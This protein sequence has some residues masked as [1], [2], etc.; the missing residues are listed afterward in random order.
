MQTQNYLVTLGAVTFS[1][2]CESEINH[3]IINLRLE[4]KDFGYSRK[5]KEIRFCGY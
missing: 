2:K 4:T 3:G 5:K 1:D